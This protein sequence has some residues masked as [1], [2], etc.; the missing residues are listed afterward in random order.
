MSGA[1]R[2][3]PALPGERFFTAAFD[4]SPIGQYLLAP[5]P[6]LEI[7]AVNDAFLASVARRRD[8]VLGKP[9]FE[10]FPS[11]PGASGDVGTDALARSIANAIAS[12]EAQLM[13]A[14]HYPIEMHRDGRSW[15]EDMYWS[16]TNTPVYDE[17]GELLCVSHTTIDITSRVRAQQALEASEEQAR[18][19]ALNA[20]RSRSY[21]AGVLQAAQVGIMVV[22]RDALLLHNNPSS[23]A[24]FGTSVPLQQGRFDFAGWTGWFR[25]GARSGDRLAPADWPLARALNGETVERCLI[26]LVPFG[27]GHAR[28]MVLVS[29]APVRNVD[30]ELVGATATAIDIDDRIRAEQALLEADRRKDEFLAM[31]A[32]ELR[33]PLAP[34]GAAASVLALGGRD[35]AQVRRTSEVITR[36][37][38]HMSDLIDE[39]L[40]VSR[41]TRGMITLTREVLDARRIVVEAL[42]QVRPAIEARRHALQVHQPPVPAYIEGDRKRLVQVLANLLN[43]ATKFTPDGG[44]IAVQLE[45]GADQVLVTVGDNGVGLTP[46]MI[47]H[48]FDLFVQAERS[49]DRRQGGLG[50]GLALVRSLVGLHG[51]SVSA[52][53]DGLGQGARFVVCLPAAQQSAA[54]LAQSDDTVALHRGERPL[55]ILIVEDNLDALSMLASLVGSL[56]HRVAAFA[57]PLQALGYA[58]E[59]QPDVCLLDIGLPGMDGMTLARC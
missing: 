22:D 44:E 47:E 3:L 28:K 37:V 23:E 50:I 32:H 6:G 53:S 24:L 17:Q 18:G 9:L 12:G 46:D 49:S 55:S 31:L 48:A 13:P 15:F 27:T 41:V 29:A 39:L 25:D 58:G 7:L 16:A 26:E 11:A 34:I 21:L 5:T 45:A 51:G 52:H 1:G 4:R 56:G 2:A 42:E 38:R 33:N 40:D 19:N 57:D 54:P 14:Q 8:E 30:G 59:A 43:N 35:P 20:E 36:Q 10:A